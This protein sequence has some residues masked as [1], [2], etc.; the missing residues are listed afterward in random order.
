MKYQVKQSFQAS[1]DTYAEH[2]VIQQEMATALWQQ[3]LHLALEQSSQEY[4]GALDGIWHKFLRFMSDYNNDEPTARE[5]NYVDLGCGPGFTATVCSLP[6][7]PTTDASPA[8][9]KASTQ[10]STKVSAHESSLTSATSTSETSILQQLTNS[11]EQDFVLPSLFQQALAKQWG[12]LADEEQR[13]Q[14]LELFT[15]EVVTPSS[16]SQQHLV[17]NPPLAS[18]LATIHAL[19]HQLAGYWY[20]MQQQVNKRSQVQVDFV[21][22]FEPEVVDVP[23]KQLTQQLEA[24]WQTTERSFSSNPHASS[25]TTL[26]LPSVTYVQSS[27]EDWLAAGKQKAHKYHLM[28]TN[29]MWQ[30]LEDGERLLVELARYR[31]ARDGVMLFGS[32]SAGHFQELATLGHSVLSYK[33]SEEL[34]KM[35]ADAKLALLYCQTIPRVLYFADPLEIIRHCKATGVN[36]K[37]SSAT[38]QA[39]TSKPWTRADVHRF[40]E[41]YQQF[42]VEGKGYPLTYMCFLAIATKR[43]A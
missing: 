43:T 29:A 26:P 40:V 23:L 9:N 17:Q 18:N 5:L 36:A 34:Q 30:W 24:L 6:N 19:E 10:T 22:L 41:D 8:N 37:L 32:F 7:P 4:P 35:F 11:Q 27:L 28:M 1:K 16:T 33:T 38:S 15:H 3:F 21:D 14:A 25:G 31:L 20:G 42:Y 13:T 39:D 2:A 12:V